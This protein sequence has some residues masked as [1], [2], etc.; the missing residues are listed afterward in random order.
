[1]RVLVVGSGGREHA[2]AW[3]LR[4]SP[5][6]RSVYVAPG[7]AGTASEPNVQNLA[8]DATDI[9]AL[10]AAAQRLAVDLTVVGPEA[11]LV[12]GIADVFRAAGLAIVGSGAHAARLEGSKSF[13]KAFMRR[14]G[15]PT[16]ACRQFDALADALRHVREHAP[17]WVIK[18]DGL[19]GGKGVVVAH[20]AQQAEVALQYLFAQ[21]AFHPPVLIEDCLVGREVSYIGLCDG[22]RFLPLETCR[23]YK[24]RDAGEQGPNT[25]GMGA[26]SP[27]PQLGAPALQRIQEQVIAPLLAGLR[28]ESIAYRG[29]LY[30]GL[31]MVDGDLPH[32]L[33]FNVRCGDPEAQALLLRLRSDLLGLLQATANG[34]LSGLEAEW[35]PDPAL[36]VVLASAGYPE[37]PRAAAVGGVPEGGDC[38]VFHGATALQRGR[39]VTPGGR[40]FTVCAKGPS[41]PEVRQRVYAALDAIV[42]PEG[43]SRRDI[44]APD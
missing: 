7:N 31:M 22:T 21:R 17:P 18:P 43:F 24:R 38:K 8:I 36:A 34:C 6:V 5:K 33:E 23:D 39:L 26:C 2:L 20:D 28:Q 29:F 16:A 40:V 15:I 3:K 27:A 14:H 41:W 13:A 9:P 4:Q 19:S 25:G 1:M 32:V 44:G 42:L 37:S 35:D 11:P 10:C 30:V 12:A